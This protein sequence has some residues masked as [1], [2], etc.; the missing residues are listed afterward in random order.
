MVK[1]R[2]NTTL[3][4]ACL[5]LGAASGSGFGQAAERLPAR[6]DGPPPAGAL[7]IDSARTLSVAIE[8]DR[9]HSRLLAY[10][11]K[12][13]P[14]VAPPALEPPRSYSEGHRVQLELVLHGPNGL[15]YTSRL[16][17]LQLCFAHGGTAPPHIEGDTIWLHRDSLIV[18]LPEIAGFEQ[19]EAAYYEEGA[20]QTLRRSLGSETLDAMRFTPAGGIARYEDLA[21]SRPGQAVG[22][23]G[24]TSGSV[25][26]PEDFNDPDLYRVYGSAGEVDRRI[27]VVIVPDGYTYAQK[28]LMRSH[29]DALVSY[30]RGMTPYKEHDPFINY[31]LVY[32][33]STESG[34]DECDCPVIRDTAMGTGFPAAGDPCGG[35]ANRC[36]YY[37]VGCDTSSENNIASAELRAPA[38]DVT[39][40]MVNTSRYGGCGGSRAVYSAANSAATD[41][42][43]HELGH[44]LAGLDDEYGGSPTCGGFAGSINTSINPIIGA[45]PEWIADLGP[46]REGAR[47]YEECIYRPAAN[48]DMRNLFQPFCPVCNQR[49]SLVFFGHPRVS[50]TAPLASMSPSSPA[51]V[52]VGVPIAF[53]VGTR[54]S[55]GPAVTNTFTWKLTEP[56]ASEPVTVATGSPSYSHAFSQEGQHV[57]SCEIVADTNFV[58]PE[59]YGTNRRSAVWT[60]NV[61]A[62]TPDGDGDGVGNSCDNCLAAPN[63]GQGD[64]D[65]DGSGDACDACPADPLN[66]GDGDL[67]CGDADNCPGAPNSDQ[68]DTDGDALGNVCDLC[69]NDPQN[70]FDGDFFCSDVDNCPQTWNPTQ[71]ESDGD[72]AGDSCDPC[73]LDPQDDGDGDGLCAN[74]DNCP[75]IP[76]FD[77]SDTDL[78]LI[79]FGQWAS[80]AGASSEY[81]PTDYSAMQATGA[82][83]IPGGQCLDRATMWSPLEPTDD[84]EWLELGYATPVP[85]TGATVYEAWQ[86]GIVYRVEL[87]D[88]QGS[89]RS[90]WSGADPTACGGLFSPSWP[91]T[92][93]RVS[94]VRVHTQAPDWEGVDAVRLMGLREEAV[95]DGVGD[96]CDNCP[97]ISNPA[98]QPLPFQQT[99]VAADAGQLS[100]IWPADVSWVRGDLAGVSGYAIS[101]SGTLPGALSLDVSGDHPASGS[102]LFY[103][104]RY[105]GACGS[106]Q[107]TPGAEPG[108]DLLL[109]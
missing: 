92:P 3:G 86:S 5:L 100:W 13:R 51:V 105:Q 93:Y 39:I 63:P 85:A 81:S 84:P 42:A 26:W 31:T 16:D 49:W 75:G 48:C 99:L 47:Y 9:D 43:A 87:R 27:N 7:G 79:E 19:L 10:T 71:A 95:P 11:V 2:T 12:P 23:G 73:P 107:S 34:T 76:N 67:V 104:V 82:P 53:S 101:A 36:L 66:D 72:G 74:A 91:A 77:Q 78:G 4:L 61:C 65:G 55:I 59:K 70:D 24:S 106:W 30:F 109:P 88:A 35:S 33:Y 56:G 21:F 69:P 80:S 25:F 58:K 98:Q 102:G 44:T 90:I 40:I 37:N 28:A 89:V 45:W 97:A 38:H 18:E 20:G 68:A 32:A 60:V 54:F 83:E 1:V 94:A 29:A 50:P 6:V 15:R 46:P 57:L 17:P 8:V 22:L 62:S 103:L 96:P 64:L 41:V 14:Y 108:R 52:D